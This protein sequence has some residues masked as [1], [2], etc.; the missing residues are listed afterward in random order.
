MEP[1]EDIGLTGVVGAVVGAVAGAVVLVLVVFILRSDPAEVDLELLV[2]SSRGTADIRVDR[3]EWGE[4]LCE[5]LPDKGIS[6]SRLSNLGVVAG[7]VQRAVL[8]SAVGAD[9]DA[10]VVRCTVR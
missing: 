6:V 5:R 3:V 10:R 4:E 7:S 8:E 2:Q 1:H 9:R